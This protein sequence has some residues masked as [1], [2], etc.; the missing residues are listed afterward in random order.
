MR[1]P[2]DGGS[3]AWPVPFAEPPEFA[4]LAPW[5]ALRGL[6]VARWMQANDWHLERKRAG[7]RARRFM[8]QRNGQV[9][10]GR[11]RARPRRI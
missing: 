5:P 9:V 10:R 2:A 11:A 8:D 1:A 4:G 3:P 7:V 6:A